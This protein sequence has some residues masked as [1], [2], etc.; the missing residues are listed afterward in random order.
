MHT[1]PATVESDHTAVAPHARAP[2]SGLITVEPLK[3]HEMQPSYAQTTGEDPGKDAGWYGAMINSLGVVVGTLGSIPCCIC[4][5]NPFK[6]VQQGNVGLVTRFG[7]FYKSV[8]PG[9]TK[10]NPL[11]EALRVVNVQ[12]T[13]I[14]VPRQVAMTKDNVNVEIDSVIYYHIKNPYKAAFGVQ[15][16][17]TALVERAQS[18]LRQVIGARS[19]QD[20]ITQREEVAREIEEILESVQKCGVFKLRAF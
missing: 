3:K 9:L 12:I 15:E 8:D 4:C 1:K 16:I 2:A 13:V 11:S 5:P 20:T 7:Q 17:R 14:A 10:I 19:L 18:T 6:E